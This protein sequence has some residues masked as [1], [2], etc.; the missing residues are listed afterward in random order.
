M[1]QAVLKIIYTDQ[2]GKRH[3]EPQGKFFYLK[4]KPVFMA[5]MT[6]AKWWK[7]YAGYSIAKQVLDAF[8][9][10]KVRPTII[11]RYRLKGVNYITNMTKFKSKGILVAYGGH[12]QYV[13]PIG[14]WE[15]KRVSS[16]GVPMN[17]PAIM[18]SEW[19]KTESEVSPV[20]P[21][22]TDYIIENGVAR[23][24]VD[25]PVQSQML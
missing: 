3:N 20:K 23:L 25:N 8:S 2:F 15:A 5:D 1:K 19:I 6:P 12:S 21:K 9:K 11:Y 14:N 18:L 4:E 16:V 13:L 10:V 24:K 7:N 22:G 17:L